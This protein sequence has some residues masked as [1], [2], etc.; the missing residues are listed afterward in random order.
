MYVHQQPKCY[1]V[2]L[3]EH[4]HDSWYFFKTDIKYWKLMESLAYRD[5]LV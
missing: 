1:Y 5:N 2:I 4:G 3:V